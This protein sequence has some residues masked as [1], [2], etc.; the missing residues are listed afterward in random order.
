MFNDGNR[1]GIDDLPI[2]DIEAEIASGREKLATLKAQQAVLLAQ[3]QPLKTQI[4]HLEEELRPISW[5]YH[6]VS[7]NAQDLE[8]QIAA[9]QN[10]IA[11]KRDREQRLALAQESIG[12]LQK[13]ASRLLETPDPVMT[14][15]GTVINRILSADNIQ[16]ALPDYIEK[17]TSYAARKNGERIAVRYGSDSVRLALTKDGQVA[18][19]YHPK[20]DEDRDEIRLILGQA[21][22]PIEAVI[23]THFIGI[24]PDLEHGTLE[25]FGLLRGKDS[26]GALTL[27]P[28]ELP[29]TSG[30]LLH[31][32]G[33]ILTN[34]S[35]SLR[36]AG[37]KETLPP[38]QP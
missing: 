7:K 34:G 9:L 12:A 27:T 26:S 8:R 37:R 10:V 24:R 16:L 36:V 32:I 22:V 14:A 20:T 13:T 21:D 18:V 29:I 25:T 3:A 28:I 31:N 17:S 30:R 5:A 6:A 4:A 23:D 19:G 1:R 11:V 15:L 2:S 38:P 35:I 33:E